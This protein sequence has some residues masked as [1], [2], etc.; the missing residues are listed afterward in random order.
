MHHRERDFEQAH[1]HG[2]CHYRFDRETQ[3]ELRV[4]KFC[5]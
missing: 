5:T 2:H 1:P 3:H 4:G